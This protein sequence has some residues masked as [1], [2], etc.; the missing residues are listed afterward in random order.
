MWPIM[1]ELEQNSKRILKTYVP[2]EI[3]YY[4][5]SLKGTQIETTPKFLSLSH[6]L[7]N[8]STFIRDMD[9]LYLWAPNQ[10]QNKDMGTY[11]YECSALA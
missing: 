8:L 1:K 2:W 6:W 7:V 3:A 4:C 9:L 10:I 5:Y 11:D